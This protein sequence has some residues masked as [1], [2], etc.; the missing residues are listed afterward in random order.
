MA[1]EAKREKR[2]AVMKEC[3]PYADADLD[4]PR[5]NFGQS[6]TDAQYWAFDVDFTRWRLELP[7][8]GSP[9]SRAK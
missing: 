5:D 8:L 3:A 2:D 6:F 1:V 7:T 9:R 4:E